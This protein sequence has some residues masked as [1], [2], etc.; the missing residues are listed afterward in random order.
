[1]AGEGLRGQSEL[2]QRVVSAVVLASVAVFTAW[3]GAW[4]FALVWCALAVAV[5]YEWS[6]IVAPERA[7]ALA[8]AM[9]A[10][11]LLL[12][13]STSLPNAFGAS[14]LAAVGSVIAIPLLARH[15]ARNW[16]AAGLAYA[17]L[18]A[19]ASVLVRG[20]GRMGFVAIFYLFAVVWMTD[21]GAYFAGRSIGGP[22]F[23]PR[24][25][26]K[27]TWS[28]VVGG[29]IAGVV[30][31]LLVLLAFGIPVRAVHALISLMLGIS[32]VF[33]DLFESFLKRRFG[34]KDA[35]ALI[36][37]HGGFLDRLDGFTLAVVLAALIGGLRGGWRDVA[38]GLLGW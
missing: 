17:Y 8:A 37:G 18:L 11:G 14:V 23:A 30:S 19:A 13:L 32:V 35:G 28:G 25:S 38:G 9:A 20:E 5:A 36:P 7:L 33:G 26:P 2:T 1:M 6:R 15:P 29:L 16:M 22:K 31:S 10:L 27:K 12:V 3:W 4:P 34:V 21:I 24:I